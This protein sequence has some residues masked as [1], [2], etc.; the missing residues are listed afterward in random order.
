VFSSAQ[1]QNETLNVLKKKSESVPL[2]SP[3][4]CQYN[5]LL[6]RHFICCVYFI[7]GSGSIFLTAMKTK[8]KLMFEGFSAESDYS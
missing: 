1:V 6:H 2:M 8:Q 7:R 4:R 3:T 5:S